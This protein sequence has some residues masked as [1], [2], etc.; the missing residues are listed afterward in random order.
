MV[1]RQAM[2]VSEWPQTERRAQ[3][4]CRWGAARANRWTLVASAPSMGRTNC[5]FRPIGTPNESV[6]DF[7]AGSW[8][9]HRARHCDERDDYV[10]P[11]INGGLLEVCDGLVS[12]RGDCQDLHQSQ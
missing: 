3:L 2:G 9:V 6:G 11:M 7:S 8:P 10:T 1:A 12:H 5:H 4:D